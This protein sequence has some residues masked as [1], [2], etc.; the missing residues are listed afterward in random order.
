MAVDG[1]PTVD[2][3]LPI[4]P[5]ELLD[6]II[7]IALGVHGSTKLLAAIALT[8]PRFR[9]MAFRHYFRHVILSDSAKGMSWQRFF[10]VL[11]SLEERTGEECFVWVRSLRAASQTLIPALKSHPIAPSHSESLA[12]LSTHLQ[13]LSIDLDSEGFVTQH[14]FLQLLCRHLLPHNTFHKL[15]MLTLTSL[16]RIDIP[17][18]RLIAGSFPLL[19]DLYLSST[20]R[21]DFHCWHCYEESLGLTIHSPVP[22]MF[23]DSRAMAVIFAKVLKP[24]THLTYLHL[25][26][27]LSDEMLTLIHA[28]HGQREGGIPFGPEECI[29][30]DKASTTVQ[31]RE[32]AAG[33][34]LAQYLKALRTVGFSS[35]FDHT[36]CAQTGDRR[37]PD[38]TVHIL[39]ENGRI[40]VRR[41]PWHD[42]GI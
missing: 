26:F 20:E 4:L 16:P 29:L 24:L 25:G 14:P 28:V 32:L 15:T 42:G 21:L 33:L 22:D 37:N 19:V 27:Y 5:V 36:P 41:S 8:S 17:L 9:S 7:E 6:H 34:E 35:F 12:V 13:E 1:G 23:S 3:S 11:R 38:T 31:L 40:R 30:C 39:R 18:L 2:K 10:R